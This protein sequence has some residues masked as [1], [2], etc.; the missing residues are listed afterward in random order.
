MDYD[1]VKTTYFRSEFQGIVN[2]YITDI[3]E[4]PIYAFD[5]FSKDNNVCYD[6][7]RPSFKALYEKKYNT[8]LTLG[9]YYKHLKKV[10]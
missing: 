9:K 5:Y 1:K 4:I 6:G 8:A 10:A 2:D 7:K 3:G